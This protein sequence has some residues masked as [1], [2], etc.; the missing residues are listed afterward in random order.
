MNFLNSQ[1]ITRTS[2]F[3]FWNTFGTWTCVGISRTLHE[4]NL[5]HSGL[6]VWKLCY[7]RSQTIRKY[8]FVG[9]RNRDKIGLSLLNFRDIG[10]WKGIEYQKIWENFQMS[11]VGNDK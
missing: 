1:K 6:L 10:Y 8:V 2:T 4:D 9:V 5:E 3:S 11:E 7:I